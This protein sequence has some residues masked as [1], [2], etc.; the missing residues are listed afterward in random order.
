MNGKIFKIAGMD[1]AEETNALRQAVGA[2]TGIMDV[3]FN[4]L[5]GT[6]T[7]TAAEGAV[8]DREI[9]SAVKRAGMI[10]Q[11]AD[12]KQAA[13]SQSGSAGF[14][15]THGR[16]VMCTAGGIAVIAGF[17]SHWLLHGSLLDAFAEGGRS[18]SHVFPAV[19]IGLYLV[20]VLAGGWFIFPKALA[21]LRR[22]RADMNLLMTIAVLG[23]LGIGEWFEAATVT[24]LFSLSLVLEAWSIGHARHAITAL[25]SLTP[26]VARYLCPHDG[27]IMEKPVEKV[28]L[29]ATVLVRPGERIPLDGEI[30]KGSSSVNQAPITGESAPVEKQEGDEVFAGT[31]NEDGAIEFRVTKPAS[32]TTIARIIRMVEEAQSRRAPSE[33]WVEK[34]ASYYTPAMILLAVA[35][36]VIPPLVFGGNW[37][38]W[39]YES[40]VL[41]VIACP[42]ALVIST[43]VSIVAAL[44]TAARSGVLIKGGAFLEEAGRL[45]VVAL[46]KTGTVT[47][48][49][50]E[51]QRIIPLNGHTEEELLD[52]AAALEL[53]SRH[54]LARAIVSKAKQSECT[55]IPAE[56]YR[57]FKGRGAQGTI[58]GRTFWIGSHRMLH[59]KQLE[60]AEMHAQ[61]DAL[62]DAGHSVVV[63]GNDDHICG[64]ISVA[65]GI[66]D[67]A[68]LIVEDL[69]SAGVEKVII[70][71]GDNQGTARAISEKIGADEC[72]AELLP[73]DKLKAIEEA[74]ERY[75]A[76]AMVGDGI[77]DAPALA[78]A[79]LGIAMAA[80]GT[81]AAMETA[82][83]ALMS[84]D[85][86]RLPWL[87]HHSR[88]TVG[89]IRQNIAFALSVKLLFMGMAIA[90]I[91]T[92]WMAITADMGASLLVIM[93]ALRLLHSKEA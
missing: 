48:G 69:K 66:R 71:T 89:I 62:E 22:F 75:G 77:N 44:A 81:D 27:D 58:D 26:A 40:L 67:N 86:S 21:A 56:N 3:E 35:I 76:V 29:G 7:V 8:D 85:L 72:H 2:L 70:L 32:D 14:W 88:R 52:R 38:R 28:P 24:F 43:P 16:A 55:L 20:A 9:I 10:A 68:L 92:L 54:P 25:F 45:K 50:P 34:F 83:I 23:A 80:A 33:Q 46:D 31:I 82:D 93:N 19:S 78:A 17:L 65:D 13:L 90:N 5:N 61:A 64:F 12:S 15:L 36:A 1:C 53:H 74:K 11:P 60:N 47:H 30:T 41:L 49:R 51:V 59:E 6:M 79:S 84:D 73:E 18:E 39:F 87:I 42:C 63:V 91:A 57:E 4:L 37:A